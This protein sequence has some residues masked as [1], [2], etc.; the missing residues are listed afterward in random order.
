MLRQFVSN[1]EHPPL[2]DHSDIPNKRLTGIIHNGG[3]GS[4]LGDRNHRVRPFVPNGA[5]SMGAA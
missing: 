4:C 2:Q 1:L 3:H 5:G